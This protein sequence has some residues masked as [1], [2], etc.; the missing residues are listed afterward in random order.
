[1]PPIT[2]SFGAL[3]AR[4]FG[5]FSA[6][7]AVLDPNFE[8][9][10]MLL[11]GDGTNGAQNNTFL[12]SSTNNFSITRN[13]NTTQGSFS[14]YGSNWSNYFDG[15]G[16]YLTTANSNVNN[17]GSSDW[18]MEFWINSTQTTRTDPLG[19]NYD[20]TSAGWAGLILN[21]SASG[22]MSWYEGTSQ[23]INATSTGWNNGAWNHIAISRSG[24]SVRM[25]LNGTQQGSTYTTSLSYGA[26]ST[27]FIVGVIYDGTGPLNGYI[28]NLR[29]VKGTAVYTSAFTPS[30]TPLTAI[31]NTSLLTCQSNRFIDNSTNAFT[32][33]R[34]GDV[35]VQRFSPFSPTA[36]YSTS[37]IGGSGYFDGSGDYLTVANNNTFDTNSTFTLECWFYQP[38]S[39]NATLFA[40]GG[41]AASWSTTDGN[42]FMLFIESGTLY[43]QW[44]NGGPT[45]I[46]TTAPAAGQW[47]HVAVG[48]N[49]TTT[50]FWLNGVSV[51]T[52]TTS[53]LLPTTRNIIRAGISPYGTNPLTGYISNLRF[54]KGTDVYGVG[55]STITVPTTPLTAITNTSLLLNYTN[56]GIFDNAMMNNLETVGNAQIS[57]SVFKYGTGSL[58]F[59]GSGDW[60]V[61]PASPNMAMG[62]GDFTWECW[63]YATA[64]N[65]Q[66]IY[67]CRSTSSNTNGFTVT[68]LSS[69]VIRVYT[70]G[71]LVTA[72]ISN[73][74][75]TW[76]HVA[77]TRAGSTNRL[78]I[79]GTLQNTATA[80]DNFSNQ[81]AVVGGGRYNS[82]N[83]DKSFTGYIDD[84]RVT[85]GYARYTTTFTPPTAAFPNQ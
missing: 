8:Y 63:I 76:T 15:S 5:L 25:F 23:R 59:D 44:N 80:S 21:V 81:V 32:I 62:T 82:N 45:S 74:L 40:R 64:A 78:F 79:N 10:T 71:V 14:P 30:T 58:A 19:W 37:V 18:T 35:S 49:G 31:A 27:G 36:A 12:D 13:G 22:Q 53:Y 54:V 72:T 24:N 2:G 11:H 33:T 66:P 1:M 75:N 43:W 52:S 3:T 38:T 70:S 41:G 42:Q 46:S 17:F 73:Y 39:G 29:I 84:L 20:Y 85:K 4:G 60:L 65:D 68:A 50:R 51:G 16:D 47:H 28:S 48:Y 57:T 61:A 56:G 55:N 26:N 77:F 9:V 83:I 67:E 69:T 34:N 7:A 6:P